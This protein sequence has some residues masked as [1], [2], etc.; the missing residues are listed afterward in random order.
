[1]NSFYFPRS[2]IHP[3][4]AQRP[5]VSQILQHGALNPDCSKSKADLTREL[6]A[7]KLRNEMLEKQLK[8]SYFWLV[9]FE[10]TVFD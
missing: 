4:P 5:K 1:M 7:E 3:D 9:R 2:M 8:V 6:S 10:R